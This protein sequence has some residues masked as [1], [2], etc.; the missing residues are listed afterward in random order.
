M[1]SPFLFLIYAEGFSG[2]IRTLVQNRDW[3]SIAMWRR[4]PIL[5]YLPFADDSLLFMDASE[6]SVSVLYR[7][8]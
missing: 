6:H 5:S 2:F 3:Q 4:A 7:T 8:F 1:L